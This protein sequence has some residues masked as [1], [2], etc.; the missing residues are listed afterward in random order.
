MKI[1]P[2]QLD[3][4]MY[5]ALET[6]LGG[7]NVYETA[8]Q[9]AVNDDLKREWTKYLAHTREHV[10]VLR[11]V[12]EQLGL[13]PEA[14]TPG[15]QVVR[16]VGASLVEAMKMALNSGG[17][18]E[19]AQIVAAEC[20][21]NAETKDHMNWEL[22]GRVALAL[23]PED[24]AALKDAYDEIEDQEDEHLYHSKGWTR[25]LWIA[26]LGLAAVLPPPEEVKK[27]ETAIGAAK[28]EASRETMLGTRASR[29]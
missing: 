17:S 29:Q 4:L 1:E 7:V 26:S 10:R 13:D 5:Q 19:A 12:C 11:E 28:A 6:E 8:L 9:C 18:P 2:S 14:E 15:R 27:V 3:E 23:G 22:I 21:V 20:I 16:H 24:G 25:E